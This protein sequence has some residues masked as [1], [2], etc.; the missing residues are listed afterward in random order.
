M[1]MSEEKVL[2]TP[3]DSDARSS[4]AVIRW[5]G[6]L[7]DYSVI[8]IGGSMAILIFLNVVLHALEKDLAWVT[9]LGEF[10]MVWVTFLGGAA[11]AQRGAHMSINEFLDKLGTSGR[12]RADAAVQ[13]F[14]TLVLAVLMYY[15]VGIVQGSWGSVLTTLEWPMAWQY[16]PLPVGAGLMLLFTGWDLIQIMRG[17]PRHQRYPADH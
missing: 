13:A 9:E 7:V 8:V 11:A 3:P 12:R 1:T 6:R 15:G 2:H 10:L 5:V 16:M 14:T 17:V 4:P